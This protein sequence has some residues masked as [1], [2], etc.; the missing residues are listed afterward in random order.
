MERT[1]S[2]Y[3]NQ[4]KSFRHD[5]ARRKL[6]TYTCRKGRHTEDKE[7]TL[8]AHSNVDEN[9]IEQ[10]KNVGQRED[11]LSGYSRSLHDTSILTNYVNYVTF[12]L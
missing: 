6:T 9:V 12:A 4:V 8:L 10:N 3:K 5:E 7:T 11:T 2:V 1:Q